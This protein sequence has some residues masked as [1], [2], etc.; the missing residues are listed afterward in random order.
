M[1]QFNLC[2]LKDIVLH[3]L[4]KERVFMWKDEL[5]E[6]NIWRYERCQYWSGIGGHEMYDDLP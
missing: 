6:T 4:D 2:E 3:P 1:M 5:K